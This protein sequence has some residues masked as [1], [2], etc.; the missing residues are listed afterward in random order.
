MSNFAH[1]DLGRLGELI[2]DVEVHLYKA[3]KERN[4]KETTVTNRSGVKINIKI[5][6]SPDTNQL[7]AVFVQDL[8]AVKS[9]VHVLLDALESL[10]N[11]ENNEELR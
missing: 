2:G 1:I 9:N 7:M 10:E 11:D 4:L 6:A 3:M 5:G 8:P